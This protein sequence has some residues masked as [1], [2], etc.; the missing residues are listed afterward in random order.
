MTIKGKILAVDDTPA[1]LK[2]LTE[3]L[4]GEG[5]EVRS[6]INGEMALRSAT[7]NPPE[8]ILLDVRMPVMDGFEVCRRLKAQPKTRE[9][10]VIFVTAL[11]ETQ[12]KVDGFEQGA[13]DFVTKP[14]QREELLSRVRT[15]LEITRLRNKLEELVE[16]RTH[17]LKLA[18]LKSADI[19]QTLQ[20]A[21]VTVD[22]SGQITFSNKAAREILEIE[23]DIEGKYFQSREWRQIDEKGQ[24]YPQEKLPLAIVLGEQKSVSN[25]EHGIIAPDG[26]TKWLSVNAAPL[27]DNS[28]HILGGVASFRDIS[29]RKM[30]E[31]TLSKLS[32][33]VEQSPNSI[34]ITDIEGKI[35]Y[36]NASFTKISG[37]RSDEVLG[38]NPRMFSAG[39]TAISTYDDMWDTLARGKV[40]E[41]EL[42]NRRKDGS[43]YFELEKISP[44]CQTDGRITHYLA[45][46]EDLTEKKAAIE[47]IDRLANFD[48][49]TGLPNQTQLN[50]L[51]KYAVSLA[52]RSGESL[53]V[54]FLDLDRF[55]N[56]N[57][58]LG[59][60]VGDNLLME[61]GKRIREALR[62]Q[63]IVSRK[64]GDEFIVVLPGID[65][66]G[67]ALVATKLLEV[68][69]SPYQFEQQELIS[70][71][72]IGIAI[73]PDDGDSL[74][75]LSKNADA[76]MY[77][78]KQ[79][80][81]N[82]FRFFT[83]EMHAHSIRALQLSNALRHALARNEL[84]LHYQP[85][86]SIDDG[87]VIGAEALL[88]WKHPELGQISPAEFIPI[89]E[90]MGMIIQ[91][92]EWV[93]R[94]ATMQMK[95]WLD[96]GL[97]PMVMAVN[98]SAVQFRQADIAERITLIVDEAK[99]PHEYLEVELTEAVTMDDPQSAINVMNRLHEQGIRMSIDDFGTGYSSLSYLKKFKVYKLKIDQSFVRDLNEDPEDKAIV[100]TIINLASSL[101]LRTIAEGVETASQLAFLR[102]HGCNEVQGYF[103]SKPLPADQLETFVKD[104]NAALAD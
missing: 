25:V 58:T 33:A 24:P 6:A 14:Y 97:P 44:V 48:Q 31:N 36:V 51:F 40:W 56:I 27:F 52:Q 8:L 20:E 69:S 10:P 101:G 59:H 4:Q 80:M 5:Y 103:F 90:D 17:E 41:G 79:D 32:L 83:P 55:K 86:L 78:V 18:E 94:T 26:Q 62:E 49:L 91:I 82:G 15:H 54:M 2:L 92:G 67:A 13:V 96:S 35:E 77:Q 23:K 46:K 38:K 99:L 1:S 75:S 64:G 65:G 16:E 93:L 43:T 87:H 76:A 21:V 102:L 3:L 73:Y 72:S 71:A 22:L 60:S 53:A 47:R 74:E 29:D 81:R 11:A 19:L 30:Y 68:I 89:A 100:S 104:S 50:D 63:D 42:L 61:T 57:D 84:Y 7:L 45:V 66:D 70:T 12:D 9:V 85:Q 88:R 37:Y 34:V 39:N 95:A 98:L 28:S